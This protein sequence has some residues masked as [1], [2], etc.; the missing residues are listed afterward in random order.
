M[1]FIRPILGIATVAVFVTLLSGCSV[2]VVDKSVPNKSAA[3]PQQS[4]PDASSEQPVEEN[5]SDSLIPGV[6]EMDRSSLS[7]AA[8]SVRRCDGEITILDD[9]IV[10]RVE[11]SCDRLIL[12]ST[13]AMIV[14][15]DVTL[16]EVI[17]DGNLVLTGAVDTVQ[18]NGTGNSVHWVGPT[19]VVQNTG[20]GNLI[21]AG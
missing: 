7:A 17:G 5:A 3:P 19:P 13:G 20:S 15:D 8:T 2:S 18:V 1:S 21:T 9:A 12:N 10:A 16:L 11:G 6:T 14:T 4:A